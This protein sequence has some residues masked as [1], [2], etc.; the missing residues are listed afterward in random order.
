MAT[1]LV[2]R[3]DLTPDQA[4]AVELSPEGHRLIVGGP[5]SGK[6]QVLLHRAAYLRSR[7]HVSPERFRIFVY[8]RALKAY[9]RAAL[10]LLDIP[11]DCVVTLDSWCA[12]Y[13]NRNIRKKKPRAANGKSTDF[14]LVR[15]GVRKDLEVSAER[16]GCLDFIMV[17]EAQDLDA[18]GLAIVRLASKHVTACLDAN[19]QIYE[20]GSGEEQVADALG[21]SRRNVSFLD[22]FRCN[23]EIAALAARFIAGAA[24]REA[25]L[26]QVRIP[27]PEREQPLVFIAKDFEEERARLIEVVRVRLAKGDRVGILLPQRRMV[28]GFAKALAEAGIETETPDKLDFSS[29]RPKLMPFPSGKGLTLDSV[30]IPRVVPYSFLKVSP[31]RLDR[32]LFVGLTRAQR[33]AYLSTVADTSQVFEPVSRLLDAGTPPAWAVQ[34]GKGTPSPQ[35]SLFETADDDRDDNSESQED[36]LIDLL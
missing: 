27:P 8:T 17:D 6:T 32:L 16:R 18:N 9:I 13:W 7:F 12:D 25:F 33:W 21:L 29:H 20:R 35:R 1:W 10:F 15:E 30:L 34:F 3:N 11:E 4:R 31:A 28:F 19:Q 23:T 5:G 14:A 2:P 26:R 36:S 24:E 22:S